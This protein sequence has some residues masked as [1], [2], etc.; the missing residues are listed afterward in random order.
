MAGQMGAADGT[1]ADALFNRPQGIGTDKEGNIY[2]ADTYNNTIRKITSSGVVSTLAGTAGQHGN[3][4]G[5]GGD[6]R[7]DD[8]EGITVDDQ[9]NAY[10]ADRGNQLIRRVTPNGTVTTLILRFD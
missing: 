4:D 8:P 5:T 3:V 2:I 6:A 10:V 1:G 7:F 9:G